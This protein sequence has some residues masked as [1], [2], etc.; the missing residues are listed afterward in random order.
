MAT[1]DRKLDPLKVRPADWLGLLRWLERVGARL[2]VGRQ[3]VVHCPTFTVATVPSVSDGPGPIFVSDETG[4]ATLAFSD[5][6][7]WRRVQDRAVI[8]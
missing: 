3:N 4:G 6:T 5:G 1:D 8:S 7:N 2:G